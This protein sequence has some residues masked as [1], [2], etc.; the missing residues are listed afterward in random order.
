[1]NEGWFDT[2]FD[3]ANLGQA[4]AAHLLSGLR[5]TPLSFLERAFRKMRLKR[6]QYTSVVCDQLMFACAVV[7]VGYVGNAFAYVVDRTSG[8]RFEWS[9]L[10]PLARGIVVADGSV[11]GR[12]MIY[13]PGWGRI[14]LDNDMD[15]GIRT[16][17]AQLEGRDGS[18]RCPPLDARFE[19]RD[20]GAHP[21]PIIVVERTDPG[22]WLYT[23]KCYGLA[24]A[25]RLSCGDVDAR[26]DFAD[27]HA[28]LDYNSGYRPRETW[29]NWA[30]AG[31]RARNGARVGFN[32]TAHRP[33]QGAGAE[34]AASADEDAADCALWLDGERIKLRRVEFDYDPADLSKPWRIVD[35]D[36]LVELSFK[37]QGERHE[38][39]NFGLVVSRFHQPYGVF[40]GTLS[41]PDGSRFAIDDVY[42]VTE[43]HFARW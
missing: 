20:D 1:V 7:D 14:V 28:G 12:T 35:A 15:Q 11:R 32:L 5:A 36:G 2:P 29:W 41:T 10:T 27:G 38:N 33:W 24:A 42:G 18:T 34:V 25:G 30:A 8:R 43:Q 17:E 23:H 31:G 21:E 37:P 22:R 4:P 3:E 6:W 40:E 13:Q 39:V 16:I 9:T 19:I 26:F